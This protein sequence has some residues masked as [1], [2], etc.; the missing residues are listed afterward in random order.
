M[1]TSSHKHA[2]RKF[3]SPSSIDRICQFQRRTLFQGRIQPIGDD[4][5][6][7]LLTLKIK[8]FFYPPHKP[9]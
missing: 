5:L 6:K 8:P 7:Y 2:I 3:F 1:L 4:V 9:R